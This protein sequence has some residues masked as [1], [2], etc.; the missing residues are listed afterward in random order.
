M[1]DERIVHGLVGLLFCMCFVYLRGQR[2]DAKSLAVLGAAT[3][4]GTWVP[5]WD[6]MAG[7][8]YHRSPLTHSLIPPLILFVFTRRLKFPYLNLGFA[9]GVAS[10]LL[11]DIVVY[12]N[13]QMI[14]GGNS[15]RLFLLSNSLIL[16][17][18]AAW[19]NRR[20]K[21]SISAE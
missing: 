13:V 5:D 9:L 15:D 17:G 19:I 6:L 16:L 4:L 2:P 12:G 14:S 11:W 21:N 18:F 8:G 10:H 7:I 3:A 1:S 20:T